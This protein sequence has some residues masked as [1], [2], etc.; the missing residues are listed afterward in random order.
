MWTVAQQC[1]AAFI[2]ALTGVIIALCSS[3]FILD[4]L[5]ISFSVFAGMLTL[6]LFGLYV[7]EW[8]YNICNP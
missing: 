8:I 4:Q 3:N 1:F 2:M 6:V 7:C 5:S